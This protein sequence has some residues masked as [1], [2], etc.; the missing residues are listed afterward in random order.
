M[1]YQELGDQ[2]FIAR[3]MREIQ[4]HGYSN[5]PLETMAY[6]LDAH[7]ENRGQAFDIGD[8]VAAQL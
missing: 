4:T 6:T 3:Y 8:H 2:A 1:A 7:F 5:A